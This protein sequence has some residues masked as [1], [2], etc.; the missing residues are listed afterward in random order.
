MCKG[1]GGEIYAPLIA[2]ELK[3][4][5]KGQADQRW[6][7]DEVMLKV[8]TKFYYL[9]RAIDSK[10]QL[11]DVKLSETRDSQTTTAF[12]EQ[13][14]ETVGHKPEQVTSDKE[15][16]YPGTIEKVLGKKVEHRTDLA[17]K[18]RTSATSRAG[19]A[20]RASSVGLK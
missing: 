16:S 10:G 18:K 14:V 11:V 13:A 12:F 6:K 9:Y 20:K 1:L 2:D 8:K 19:L 17:K 7:A 4:Q 3:A 15:V 5:R